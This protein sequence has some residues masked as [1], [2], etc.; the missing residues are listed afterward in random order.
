MGLG[1]L[2]VRVSGFRGPELFFASLYKR[3]AQLGLL[4]NAYETDLE[5]T[6]IVRAC[7]GF[8]QRDSVLGH[9]PGGLR[10][11]KGAEGPSVL[12]MDFCM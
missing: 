2:G 9:P 7:L 8:V 6:K 10:L 11:L 5:L 4:C 1:G 3:D 12:H